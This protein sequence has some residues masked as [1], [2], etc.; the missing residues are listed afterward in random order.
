MSWGVC[1]HDLPGTVIALVLLTKGFL[2]TDLQAA[3][4]HNHAL[5]TASLL[6]D[7]MA[8]PQAIHDRS[9]PAGCGASRAMEQ[10]QKRDQKGGLLCLRCHP[11]MIWGMEVTGQRGGG[12]GTAATATLE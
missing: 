2:S 10:V 1:P 11:M 7:S 12:N 8:S 4:V 9:T 5:I 6:I 3:Q